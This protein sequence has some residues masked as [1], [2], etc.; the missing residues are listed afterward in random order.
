MPAIHSQSGL[1]EPK[2]GTQVWLKHD[3]WQ[4]GAVTGVSGNQI[5][6]RDDDGKTASVPPEGAFL[7]GGRA[8]GPGVADMIS[9][10]VLV[11]VMDHLHA[12]FLPCEVGCS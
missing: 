6:V 9:L 11:S 12:H 3:L 8:A 1:V 10:G 2:S 4:I 5:S 7:C